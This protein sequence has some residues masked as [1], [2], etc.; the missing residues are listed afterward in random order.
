MIKMSISDQDLLIILIVL[1]F[2]LY[3]CRSSRPNSLNAKSVE[4]FDTAITHPDIEKAV[5]NAG[6]L[7]KKKVRGLTKKGRRIL[8]TSVLARIFLR[9]IVATVPFSPR[10]LE[11]FSKFQM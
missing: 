1:I 9:W 10:W 8:T 7:L 4:K 5:K 3:F 11:G 2:L 6:K